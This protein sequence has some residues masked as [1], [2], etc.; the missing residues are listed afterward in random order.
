V[1]ENF[2]PG[3]WG[4]QAH[5][6]FDFIAPDIVA[7]VDGTPFCI[8]AIASDKEHEMADAHLIAAAP[9][10]YKFAMAFLSR[11]DGGPGTFA[12]LK[13][14]AEEATKKARGHG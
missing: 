14:W 12:T 8:A 7:R 9:Q 2:T 3:P 11:L 6:G 4:V 10:L 1:K 13:V 5:E